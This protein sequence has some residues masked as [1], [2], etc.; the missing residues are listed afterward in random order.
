[1]DEKDTNWDEI[2]KSILEQEKSVSPYNVPEPISVLVKWK[3]NTYIGSIQ[4][5]AEKFSKE[6][7][8]L[9]KSTYILPEELV[10]AI[11]KLDKERLE[12]Y[13]DESLDLEGRQHVIRKLDNILTFMTTQQTQYMIEH[14]PQVQE[15]S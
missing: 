14:P 12:L 11:K 1:M 8:L 15:I 9:S 6:I 4:L 13:A 5:I 7:V 2:A 10:G 3:G